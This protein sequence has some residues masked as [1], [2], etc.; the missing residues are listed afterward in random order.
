MENSPYEND[1]TGSKKIGL[2]FSKPCRFDVACVLN[3]PQGLIVE[4]QGAR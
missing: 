3:S 4:S 2:P 1:K